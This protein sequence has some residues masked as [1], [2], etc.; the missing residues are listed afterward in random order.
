M[1]LSIYLYVNTINLSTMY[2]YHGNMFVITNILPSTWD[3][4]YRLNLEFPLLSIWPILLNANIKLDP[5][6]V[7][8][9]C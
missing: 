1:S 2:Q 4:D 7:R 9:E 6:H 8:R 3:A 5:E